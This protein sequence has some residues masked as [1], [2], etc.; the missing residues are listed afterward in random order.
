MTKFIP[1]LLIV[2]LVACSN[3]QTETTN[4]YTQLFNGKDLTGW[5][6][7]IAGFKAG[8][9]YKNTFKVEDGLLRVSYAEYD[10][11]KGEFGHLFFKDKFSDYRLR[12][13]YRFAKES[14]KGAPDWAFANSGVMFHSQSA[15][16]MAVD[17]NF[18]VSLEAQFLGSA[19]GNLRHTMNLCTPGMHVTMADTLTTIHCID[20]NSKSFMLGDW[21]TVELIVY[22]DSIIHH[23]VGSDTVLTY[24]KPI[25]GGAH[26]PEADSALTGRSVKEGYISLQAEGHALDFRKVEYMELKR[27]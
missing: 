22:G 13:E 15:E 9:N 14:T 19:E 23:L 8:E 5:T 12:I 20:S 3:P 25:I 2:L 10:S 11:F 27:N 4:E 16:S 24:S 7:K 1:Q 18:P 26:L 17:Q 21:V 6:P